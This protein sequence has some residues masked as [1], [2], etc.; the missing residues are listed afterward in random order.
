M[1]VWHVVSF[2][3]RQ[4][5]CGTLSSEASRTHP[6]PWPTTFLPKSDLCGGLC[7]GGLV[8]AAILTSKLPHGGRQLC[9]G[10]WIWLC[11]STTRTSRFNKLKT[12]FTSVWSTSTC[13]TSFLRSGL[14]LP[15]SSKRGVL[16]DVFDPR[17]AEAENE[18][19]RGRAGPI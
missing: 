14:L 10:F 6:T 3:T 16:C 12:D 19:L 7:N 9:L 18:P 4:R 5:M 17:M 2:V 13:S 15:A 11:F 8:I 1:Q